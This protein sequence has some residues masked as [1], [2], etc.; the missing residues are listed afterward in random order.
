MINQPQVE[1]KQLIRSSSHGKGNTSFYEL[2]LNL[3]CPICSGRS[4]I[5]QDGS[6]KS[7]FGSM[8]HSIRCLVH[9][10]DNND[11]ESSLAYLKSAWN[12]ELLGTDHIYIVNVDSKEQL[13]IFNLTYIFDFKRLFISVPLSVSL[14]CYN[15]KLTKEQQRCYASLTHVFTGKYFSSFCPKWVCQTSRTL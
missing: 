2:K 15:W 7:S 9:Y 8:V 10:L 1:S 4:V 14:N 13:Q 11:L 12:N 3:I 5:I 6:Q